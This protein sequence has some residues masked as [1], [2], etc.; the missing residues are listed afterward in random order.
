MALLTAEH[1]SDTWPEG[2]K[3]WDEAILPSLKWAVAKTLA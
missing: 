2:V 1:H 3:W